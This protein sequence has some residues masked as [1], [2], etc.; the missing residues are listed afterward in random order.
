MKR[1]STTPP[2]TG[3]CAINEDH[4][5]SPDQRGARFRLEYPRELRNEEGDDGKRAGE[6]DLL[7]Q[8]DAA[9]PHA[10]RERDETQAAAE[11]P[12]VRRRAVFGSRKGFS[13]FDEIHALVNE[14]LNRPA[15]P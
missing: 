2:V 10:E 6:D 12:P 4:D 13:R 7:V 1:A 11:N 15:L 9:E 14:P 8:L 3:N 5:R